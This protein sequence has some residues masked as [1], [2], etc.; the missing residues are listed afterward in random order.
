MSL[1]DRAE[2]QSLVERRN[3][4]RKFVWRDKIILA[5]VGGHGTFEIMRRTRTSKPTAWHLQERYLDAGVAKMTR[6]KTTPSRGPLL[7]REARLKAIAKTV[8]ES[9]PN[10]THWSHSLMTE[11]LG[12]SP[13]SV[14]RIWAGAGLKTHLTRDFKVSTDPLFGEKVTE[15]VGLYLDPPKRV[16]VLN[17]NEKSQ[18]Q[19]PNRTKPS[20]PRKKGHSAT[21]THDHKRRGTTTLLAALHVKSGLVWSGLVWGSAITCHTTAQGSSSSS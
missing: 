19:A 18:I 14:G 4:R 20:L 10:A 13:S 9:Y 17:V 3:T 15:I 7:P 6:D 1:D 5:T 11:A 8:Q 12:V 16:V 2:P 21:M